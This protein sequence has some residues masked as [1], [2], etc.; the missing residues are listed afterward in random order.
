MLSTMFVKYL[1][2]PC[3][4]FIFDHILKFKDLFELEKIVSL[5]G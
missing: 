2:I 5:L 1:N 4:L 3:L